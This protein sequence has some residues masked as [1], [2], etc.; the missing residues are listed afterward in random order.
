MYA[1][2]NLYFVGLKLTHSFPSS[3]HPSRK[4][5][6]TWQVLRYS[7]LTILTFHSMTEDAFQYDEEANQGRVVLRNVPS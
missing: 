3:Y 5:D 2:N 1:I 6:T 4:P 7:S